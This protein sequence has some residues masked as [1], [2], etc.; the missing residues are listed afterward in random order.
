MPKVSNYTRTRIELLHKQ[1]LHPAGIFRSLKNEGL[2]VSLASVSRIVK[3]L[4]TTGSVANLPRSGRPTK[5]SVDAKAFIDQQM[6]ENDETTSQQIQKKLARRGIAV[7]SSTVRRS[8]QQQ[9]WTLQRTAY[10]QLIRDANKIKRLEYARRVLDSGDTF[11]NVIFSDECSISL[12]QYRRTCYRK[13]DEPT[14]RKPKPKHPL[15]CDVILLFSRYAVI[16]E[17]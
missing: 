16:L 17:F 7:S 5:L 10:C 6:R 2:L 14:K 8:R 15:F 1:G 13:I 12:Q 3:K 11:H 4:K 9:G